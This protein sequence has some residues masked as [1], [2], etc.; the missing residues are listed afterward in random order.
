M[1]T[2]ETRGIDK[3]K[4]VMIALVSMAVLATAVVLFVVMGKQRLPPPLTQKNLQKAV[5]MGT[6]PGGSVIPK[7]VEEEALKRLTAPTK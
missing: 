5:D 3:K 6:A 2:V 7:E 4:V 1:D